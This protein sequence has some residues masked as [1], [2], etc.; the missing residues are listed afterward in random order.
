MAM[1]EL[2]P[3]DRGGSCLWT[4]PSKSLPEEIKMQE[5]D[6]PCPSGRRSTGS[7]VQGGAGAMPNPGCPQVGA[8][9]HVFICG[10]GLLRASAASTLTEDEFFTY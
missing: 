7:G 8:H 10:M 6:G 2:C 9:T 1:N 4:C 3:R 5:Q